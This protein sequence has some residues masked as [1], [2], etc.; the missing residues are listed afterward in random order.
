MVIA[1]SFQ[2]NDSNTFESAVTPAIGILL[3]SIS[4]NSP[5]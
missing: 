5:K 4:I 1:P 2:L 3:K